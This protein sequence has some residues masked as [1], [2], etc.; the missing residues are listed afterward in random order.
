MVSVVE[1]YASHLAPVYVWMAGG[2]EAALA[3][4]TQDV[5][6][7]MPGRGVAVDLGAGF[8]MHS[9]PLA[10]AGYAVTAIDQS[11]ALLHTLAANSSGLPIRVVE[12]DL[13]EFRSALPERAQLILCMGD[14]LTHLETFEQVE[15]LCEDVQL[16]LAAGGQFIATFRDYTSPAAGEKRFIPVRSDADRILTCFLEE[17]PQHMIVHDLL[18]ERRG[19]AWHLAVSSY[20]KLRLAPS[21]LERA[22]SQL[23]LKVRCESGPRGMVRVTADAPG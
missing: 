16:S 7:L 13:L 10:R 5:A 20:R 8:G 23:G 22:L 17:T 1:H 6:S 3:V 11:P 18:H 15:R 14:T 4:G 2:I 9:I 19:E 12:S 21:D